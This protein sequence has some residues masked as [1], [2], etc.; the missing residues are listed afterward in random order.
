[1]S[2]SKGKRGIH[3]PDSRGKGYSLLPYV[4]M[5]ALMEAVSP[6]AVVAFLAIVRRFN[7]YNNGKIALS[8]RDLAAIIGSHN[9]SNKR[10]L[11]ELRDGGFIHETRYPKGQRKAT[12][13]RLTFLS[14]GA[15][16]E[17]PAKSEYLD[18]GKST[19]WE[20]DTREA[21]PVSESHTREKL[22]ASESHTGV[23]ET[24]QFPD[25]LPVLESHTHIL[26]HLGG[27]SPAPTS[28]PATAPAPSGPS[29][30]MEQAELHRAAMAYLAKAEAGTQTE[31]AKE[32]KIPGGVFSKFLRGQRLPEHHWMSLQLE[33]GRRGALT[34]QPASPVKL[35]DPRP[36]VAPDNVTPPKK[37]ALAWLVNPG[38]VMSLDEILIH[39]A[40]AFAR[41][42]GPCWMTEPRHA[43]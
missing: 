18:I 9:P 41:A 26:N 4:T 15:N 29:A 7:G 39:G 20:T 42:G 36:C 43:A 12:E 22:R 35:V 30:G 14:Y 21:Q 24:S 3:Q 28:C 34:G 11:K 38:G 8:S 32:A 40:D 33:L 23:T 2:K 1:M 25:P 31:I 37:S 19:V 13:Y 27:S 10:A 5:D 6:R 17:H 16:G